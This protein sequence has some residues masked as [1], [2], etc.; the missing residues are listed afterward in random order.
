MRAMRKRLQNL[1]QRRSGAGL[2][3]VALVLRPDGDEDERRQIMREY[4][5]RTATGQK[6]LL[7][8]RYGDPLAALVDEIGA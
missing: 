3:P 5:E 4:R 1:E 6:V 7:I 8:Y 2:L